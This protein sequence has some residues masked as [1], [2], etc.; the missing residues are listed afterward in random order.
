MWLWIVERCLS[1]WEIG[2]I[3][4]GFGRLNYLGLSNASVGLGHVVSRPG[5]FCHPLT[6]GSSLPLCL[7]VRETSTTPSISHP[8]RIPSNVD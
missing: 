4:E 3:V 2:L 5:S 8:Y 7:S 6:F 1:D